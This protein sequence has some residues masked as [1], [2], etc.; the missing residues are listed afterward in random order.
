MLF[1]CTTAS[2]RGAIHSYTASIEIG[3][4]HNVGVCS[5]FSGMGIIGP[6]QFGNKSNNGGMIIDTS[7]VGIFLITQKRIAG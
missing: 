6:D 1:F 7:S 4:V 3:V 5:H 2:K